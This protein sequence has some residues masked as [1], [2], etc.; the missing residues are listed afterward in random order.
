MEVL[1]IPSPTLPFSAWAQRSSPAL[2]RVWHQSFMSDKGFVSRPSAL[3]DQLSCADLQSTSVVPQAFAS[4]SMTLDSMCL[5]N[6]LQS[7]SPAT[8]IANAS[9]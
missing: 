9:A 6:T 7:L 2:R 1:R 8:G 3:H 5:S 4:T